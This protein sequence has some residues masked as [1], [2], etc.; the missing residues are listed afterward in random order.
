MYCGRSVERPNNLNS[1]DSHCEA[2]A[3]CKHIS[4]ATK[5]RGHSRDCT[6]QEQVTSSSAVKS[7]DSSRAAESG[8][9]T[10]FGEHVIPLAISIAILFIMPIYKSN[11]RGTQFYP[12][13]Q[14]I[15]WVIA[16]T[17]VL[18]TWIGARPVE[19]PYILT[20]QV[21]TVTEA[22]RAES[23]ELRED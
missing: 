16:N 2:I 11:F 12:I 17:V 1:R 21:L 4:T 5:S 10:R 13:N 9:F 14:I 22:I 8:V 19:D 23:C 18:L 3:L 15:F 6:Q 20:G 7:R